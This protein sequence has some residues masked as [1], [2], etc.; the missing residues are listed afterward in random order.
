MKASTCRVSFRSFVN[1]VWVQVRA[2]RSAGRFVSRVLVSA[3]PS[4]LGVRQADGA[5][6][7]AGI[8]EP[9]A[10]RVR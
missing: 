6:S 1:L 5:P 4:V 3:A 7:S 8:R 10:R 9:A 2:D